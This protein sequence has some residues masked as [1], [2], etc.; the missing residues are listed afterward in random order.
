MNKTESLGSERM[1]ELL[2]RHARYEYASDIEA[3]MATVSEEPV[4]EFHPLGL[5]AEGRDAVR[6]AYEYQFQRIFPNIIETSRRLQTSGGRGVVR[7]INMR[8]RLQDGA[9]ANGFCIIAM[10]FQPDGLITSERSYGSGATADLFEFCFT[11]AIW[12]L[13]GVT[14]LYG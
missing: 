6:A 10:E 1:A 12:S 7:E 3:T 8:I 2:E 14:R 11:D 9:E 4:W 13:P 5:R